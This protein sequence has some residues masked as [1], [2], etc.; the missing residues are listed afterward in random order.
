MR[1]LSVAIP[2][3]LDTRLREHLIRED[4]QEDLCFAL[5]YPSQGERRY[6][7]LIN[8]I[9]LPEPGDRQVH[10]NV[11]FNQQFLERACQMACSAGTARHEASDSKAS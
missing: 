7:A 8:S 10:G 3:V 2:G 9:I 4:G 1:E 5:W 11:S 6:T